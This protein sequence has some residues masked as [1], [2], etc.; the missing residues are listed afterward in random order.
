MANKWTAADIPSQ[1]GKT[2]VVTGANSGLGLATARELAH[3]GAR[4]VAAVR[5]V[6]KGEAAAGD[7]RAAVPDAHLTV[8]KLDLSDLSSV[9][10]FAQRMSNQQ[11]R[12]D[13][14]INNAGVVA[15]PRRTTVDGF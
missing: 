2:A 12:V 8:S 1:S 15:P 9:R 7:I 4:V 6:A 13:L 11:E 10:E 14:L 3:A 5:D